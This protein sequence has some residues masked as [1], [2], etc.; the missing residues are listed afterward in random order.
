MNS[1]QCP[2]YFLYNLV[3]SRF[4]YNFVCLVGST[5][6]KEGIAA[7][8]KII[9][10]GNHALSARLPTYSHVRLR[11]KIVPSNA[12]WICLLFSLIQKYTPRML[13]RFCEETNRWVWVDYFVLSKSLVFDIIRMS[14]GKICETDIHILRTPF[15]PMQIGLYVTSP[16]S[17][18]DIYEKLTQ[19]LEIILR[20]EYLAQT[21]AFRWFLVEA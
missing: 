16:V 13:D 18:P 2:N 19:I 11:E 17:H 6:R 1:T 7:E 5:L 12:G 15:I 14:M 9:V 10:A 4:L 20:E 3:S 21:G 8:S